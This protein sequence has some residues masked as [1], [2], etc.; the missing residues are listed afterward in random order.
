MND[1]GG[2]RVR[3]NSNTTKQQNNK[4]VEIGD[5]DFIWLEYWQWPQ[6]LQCSQRPLIPVASLEI[7]IAVSTGHQPSQPKQ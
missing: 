3:S 4:E 1:G 2:G 6:C 7:L 5:C